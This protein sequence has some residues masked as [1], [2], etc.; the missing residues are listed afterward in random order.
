MR[1][2]EGL[3]IL[4]FAMLLHLTKTANGGDPETMAGT[5]YLAI[6]FGGYYT[7][8][9]ELSSVFQQVREMAQSRGVVDE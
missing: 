9:P 8:K 5:V 2:G 6:I 7:F 3:T 4:N 1:I